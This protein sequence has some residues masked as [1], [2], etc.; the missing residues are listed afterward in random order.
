[1]YAES[2]DSIR[3]SVVSPEMIKKVSVAKLAIPDTYNE[4]GYPIDGGLID[5]R[6]GVIDPGLRCKT[7]GGRAKSCMGH[8]GH[9]E[10]IRPVIHPEFARL[11]FMIM[12]STCDNC[13]RVLVS[14]KNID[15]LRSAEDEQ[16]ASMAKLKSI[17]KCPH[18]GAKQKKLKFE[19]PTFFYMDG[20]RLKSDSIKDW[21][22]KISDNDLA[23]IGV[24]G[25]T[26]RPEWAIL[27]VLIVPPVNVRPSITLENGDRSEDDLTHKLVEV[28]RINQRLEQDIDAGAPQIIIDDLWELLQY[29]V[30]TYFNNETPGVPVARHRSTRP[31]KT[32]SHRLKGKEGRLRYN[33]SGKRVNFT[34]RTVICG[35]PN[36]SINE[37]GVAQTIAER[38]TTPMHVTH[39]NIE[40]AKELIDRREYPM[41]TNVIN[42]EG[43]RKRVTESNRI[44]LVS[45]IAPG[46]IVERQ[47]VDNDVA[48]FNRQPTL[49][50]MSIMAH[51]IRVLPGK[52]M[53]IS[54]NATTPYNA[55]F[56]GDEMNLHIPQSIEAIAEA[57]Y[58]MR[59][60]D[61]ILTP[62]D[63]SPVMYIDE[64]G[65]VGAYFLTS[66]NT[67][68]DKDEVCSM[69][70]YAG[71]SELPEQDR[72]G[73]YSGKSIFSVL[74]PKGLNYEESGG[75]VVIKDGKLVEGFIRKQTIG[76]GKGLLLKKIYIDYGGEAVADF[77]Y[78]LTRVT[79]M[80][81][82]ARGFTIGIKDYL[83]NQNIQ[84][85]SKKIVEETREQAHKI[86]ESYKDRSMEILPGYS[87]R[88]TYEMLVHAATGNA[89]GMGVK[90]IE[91]TFSTDNMAFL[92]P[93]LGARGGIQNFV[94][95]LMFIGQQS[96][97]GNRITRGYSGR[98]I[99]YFKKND[100]SPEAKGFIASS[101]M[102]GL[103]PKEFYLHA[104][105]ARDST[106]GKALVTAVS[107]Y[108][109]RRLIHALQDIYVESDLS[110]RNAAGDIIQPI[111]GS[112]GI[113]TIYETL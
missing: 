90:Y 41:A 88:E 2:I 28:M 11:V 77:I 53:R 94:Q 26:V 109:M 62:R 70:A 78:K 15:I 44:E 93:T 31:L 79:Y 51:R 21:M 48:L 101:F 24:D 110:V 71:I 3:F 98:V 45:S 107:G 73:R 29:H 23:V 83:T 46:W 42:S 111:Y 13:Y 6:L 18:C 63:G 56:D 34:A 25:N 76:G 106:M 27:S 108:L 99:P 67:Y 75:A 81:V 49:H 39:W 58:M 104:M 59:P 47:L 57:R 55:D 36:L 113:D 64:E 1:M 54:V 43:V 30:T 52:T 60:T 68:F 35:D 4:D 91:K 66:S 22:S 33:L 84:R 80:V 5:Q 72:D 20:E 19:R 82:Y 65:I 87:N 89:R 69:L 85:E 97:R 37:V 112:D 74:L 38:L 102:D 105:G 10:L 61:V 14:E 96:V 8:F 7:C 17:K 9:L 16:I 86:L 50:K 103:E 40:K 12:Q 32:L 95:M 100:K 92:I